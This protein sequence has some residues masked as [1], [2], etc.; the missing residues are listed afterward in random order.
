MDGVEVFTSDAPELGCALVAFKIP[1]VATD[2][3]N[4]IMW[5]RHNIYIRNVTHLEVDWDVNRVSLHVMVTGEQVDRF[6]GA[7]EEVAK[8]AKA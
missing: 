2:D 6:L 8:A 5:E 7:V 4:D 1:G 3:L